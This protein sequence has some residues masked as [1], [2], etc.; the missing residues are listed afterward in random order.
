MYF[1]MDLKSVC[2]LY[3]S[4]I[5]FFFFVFETACVYCAVRNECLSVIQINLCLLTLREG[6]D[7]IPSYSL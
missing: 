4:N 6:P 2:F 3:S 1:A 7:S 5:L